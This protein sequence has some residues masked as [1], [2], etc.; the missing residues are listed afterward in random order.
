VD[1]KIVEDV[2]Q[3]GWQ[4]AAVPED[5]IGPGIA[6]IIGLAHSYGAPDLAMFG[7]S[8]H[9]SLGPGEL[10]ARL[11]AESDAVMDGHDTEE[12]DSF[13]A[14]LPGPLRAMWLS[15]AEVPTVGR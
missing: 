6:Y 8:T 3:L 10:Q 2:K 1:A 5:E 15:A 7:L 9:A 11:I 4:V 13:L 12:E 14:A